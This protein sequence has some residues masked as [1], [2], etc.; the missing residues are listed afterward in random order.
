MVGGGLTTVRDYLVWTLVDCIL[1]NLKTGR[2][3]SPSWDRIAPCRVPNSPQ[4][5]K[6]LFY[7][8]IPQGSGTSNLW[9]DGY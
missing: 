9:G 4:I 3:E 8:R 6:L 5:R 1:S 7:R 2:D